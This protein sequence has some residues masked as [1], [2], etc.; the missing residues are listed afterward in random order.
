MPRRRA[1][2]QQR[3]RP[4]RVEALDGAAD[5]LITGYFE[6]LVEAA[7]MPRPGFRVPLYAPPA[8]LG[9]AQALLDAPAARHAARGAGQR[10]AAASSPTSPIRSTR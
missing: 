10:C 5:G 1:W 2:L 9:D 4:Y 7:R 8:D 3:L 6:P